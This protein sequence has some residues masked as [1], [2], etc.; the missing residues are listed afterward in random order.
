[1]EGCALSGLHRAE[2]GFDVPRARP[3]LAVGHEANEDANTKID[4]I[5]ICF[6]WSHA[7]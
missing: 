2:A 4:G 5:L 1:M 3:P 7:S 6:F